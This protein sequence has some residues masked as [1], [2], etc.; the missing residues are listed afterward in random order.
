MVRF[1]LGA[2]VAFLL[3]TAYGCNDGRNHGSN[4]PIDGCDTAP[5]SDFLYEYCVAECETDPSP[6]FC[7]VIC[8][9]DPTLA[10]CDPGTGGTGGDGGTGGTA[11]A[12]GQG[13]E[14]GTGGQPPECRCD[15]D[16]DS[17]GNDCTDDVC[18]DGV[19]EYL[20]VEV[21][22]ECDDFGFC[23]ETAT[24]ICEEEV[25]EDVT[26][27]R[28][29]WVKYCPKTFCIKTGSYD[30]CHYKFEKVYTTEEVCELEEYVC[31]DGPGVALKTFGHYDCD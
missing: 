16:C 30:C 22:T 29:D 24:C 27:C 25:C 20:P 6:A 2:A 10:F 11:G 8:D 12:G 1:I 17:D 13:G 4:I 5:L 14:G 23:D 26:T 15:D 28:W 7:D 9:D 19:C 21:G 3:I 31:E 18:V